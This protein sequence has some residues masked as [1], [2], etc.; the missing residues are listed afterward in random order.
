MASLGGAVAYALYILMADHS[1]RGGRDAFSL[2]AWGFVF[3]ALFWTLVQPWWSFP[4]D[5]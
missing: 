4:L 3:A 1:L 5:S 2:L